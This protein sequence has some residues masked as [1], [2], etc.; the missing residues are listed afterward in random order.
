MPV[1]RTCGVEKSEDLFSIR[2]RTAKIVTQCKECKNVAI[3][4]WN[5]AHPERRAETS[6]RNYAK[7]V[8][9]DPE[10][11]RGRIGSKEWETRKKPNKTPYYHRNKEK[12][13]AQVTARAQNKVAEISAYHKKWRTLNAEKKAEND[14][15]WRLGNPDLVALYSNT[16]RARKLKSQPQWLTEVQLADMREYYEIA[17]AQQK[18]TGGKF[19]VDHIFPLHGAKFCG[20]H[21]PWNLQILTKTENLQKGR[22]VPQEYAHMLDYVR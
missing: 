22:S 8:G 19:H 2:K 7:T 3:N 1:C 11:C 20:L 13:K 14:R 4:A 10:D 5:K 6:H 21:V 16:R 12:V 18:L 9:K 17:A 15:Q